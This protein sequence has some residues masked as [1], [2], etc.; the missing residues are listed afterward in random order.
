[1]GIWWY[2]ISHLLKEGKISEV[3]ISEAIITENDRPGTMWVKSVLEPYDRGPTVSLACGMDM[4][5]MCRTL[6]YSLLGTV[7]SN[8]FH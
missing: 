8:V 1:M 7:E 5:L 2:G 3:E 4:S 6:V